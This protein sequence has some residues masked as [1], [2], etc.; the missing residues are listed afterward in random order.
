MYEKA[1][2]R[3]NCAEIQE[4]L[5][6]KI[7]EEVALEYVYRAPVLFGYGDLDE[8]ERSA[9]LISLLDEL[10]QIIQSYDPARSKF[11]TYLVALVRMHARGWR[12]KAAKERAAEDS[13][14]YCYRLECEAP[15]FLAENKPEYSVAAIKTATTFLRHSEETLIVLTLK[16]AYTIS[17]KQIQVIANITGFEK[18]KLTTMVETIRAELQNKEAR[19]NQLTELRNKAFFLK[20]KYRLE[21][22]RMPPGSAQYKSVEKQYKFQTSMVDAKNEILRRRFLLVPSNSRIA[23]LLNVSPRRVSRLIEYLA[24]SM[25]VNEDRRVAVGSV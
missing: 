12:R 17:E 11:L 14:V 23:E 16:A 7:S 4:I 18:N 20:T 1:D 15:F 2:M 3:L 5:Q 24:R 21:L 13:L 25:E 9:F 6:E 19:R 10:P 8:D 22:E